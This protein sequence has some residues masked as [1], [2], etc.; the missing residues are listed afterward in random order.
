MLQLSRAPSARSTHVAI[1]GDIINSEA[2]ASV[3]R[4]HQV[5]NVAIQQA[6]VRHADDILVPLTITLGDEFQGLCSSLTAGLRVM[7]ALRYELLSKS[8]ECRF[9]LGAVRLESGLP[10][11]RAW[12]MM[13]PGL[14]QTRE[15]LALKSH[16]NAYRFHLPAD[17][18]VEDLLE[19]VGYGVTLTELDWTD[20]QREVSLTALTHAGRSAELATELG[21]AT[22][23][24]YKIRQSARLDFYNNQW[25]V[26][27]HALQTLDARYGF[28][29]A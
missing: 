3:T 5:F 28:A 26:M 11:E 27:T 2:T 12:N 23:T 9:A 17:A 15:K 4:L 21:L 25:D 22:R 29:A 14:A 24:F 1:M 18:L 10:Q 19:A 20:R 7:R 8:V 16:P 13:G 6:N